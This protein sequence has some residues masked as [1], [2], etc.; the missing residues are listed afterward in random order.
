MNSKK[1]Q[2]EIITTVLIILLVLA[3]IVIVWQVVNATLTGTKTSIDWNVACTGLQMNI[4]SAKSTEV[5]GTCSHPTANCTTR[6]ACQSTGCLSGVWTNGTPEVVVQRNTQEVSKATLNVYS[7]LYT[8]V[9][10]NQLQVGSDTLISTPLTSATVTL[11]NAELSNT[12]IIVKAATVLED[13]QKAG[14][15][16]VCPVLSDEFRAS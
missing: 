12:G 14:V 4:L 10:G 6:T 16:Q 9:N 8:V 1:A 3:A 11:T 7:R 13:T 15:R 5:M 2:S